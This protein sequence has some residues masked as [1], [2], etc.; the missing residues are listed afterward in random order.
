M[1]KTTIFLFFLISILFVGCTTQKRCN[2][3]YPTQPLIIEKTV[4]DSVYTIITKHDTIVNLIVGKDTIIHSID[5]VI[6]EKG[7]INSN[8][9]TINGDYATAT[10]KVKN[11]KIILTLTERS[12]RLEVLLKDAN[13]NKLTFKYLYENYY[14]EN[15]KLIKFIPKFYKFCLYWFLGTVII[16]I[17]GGILKIKKV[18]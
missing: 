12:K 6:I 11:S 17:V 16:V 1:N 10:G 8:T 9:I 5:T 4:H 18:I 3:K 15:T 13:I 14:K 2:E 7:L